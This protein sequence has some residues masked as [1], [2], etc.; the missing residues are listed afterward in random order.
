MS[1][2]EAY[3]I[4]VYSISALITEKVKR[5]LQSMFDHNVINSPLQRA[6]SRSVRSSDWSHF[7]SLHFAVVT[8]F[9]QQ[10]P[11][12]CNCSV[13]IGRSPPFTDKYVKVCI[14]CF[15]HIQRS[16]AAHIRVCAARGTDSVDH[17]PYG[18]PSVECG[19]G[20]LHS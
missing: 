15:A 17:S 8:F 3:S 6:A 9:C 13:N 16:D 18:R 10:I 7:L 2:R 12:N 14:Y 19:R 4:G 1:F 5:T 11:F 20:K